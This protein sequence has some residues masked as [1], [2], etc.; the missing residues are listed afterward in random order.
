M[1]DVMVTGTRHGQ[2]LALQVAAVGLAG[3]V[4]AGC[5]SGSD[6]PSAQGDTAAKRASQ[7]EVTVVQPGRPGEP[8][9]T[10]DPDQVD[11]AT[12]WNHS[13]VAFVQM[14]VPHHDQALEMAR[15]ATRRA[16]SP[17][18]EALARRIRGSQ[19]PEIITLAAWL[20]E[21]NIDVPKAGEKAEEYDH[22]AHGHIGMRGMLTTEEMDRLRGARGRA[23]DRLF[24]EG[25]IAHH[26]G[27][28][29]MAEAVAV[30]GT[31]PRVG[32]IAADLGAGQ[33]AEIRRMQEIRDAL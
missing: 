27:A 20:Q 17:A 13:D 19:G 11:E 28:V 30:E 9:A 15:L 32:E 23:F 12:P 16:A 31:D 6:T 4:A 22:G 29:A 1:S 8:L 14:M 25:M 5:S 24:L 21:R 7:G 2:T 18:V 26:E 33:S 3:L 10:V